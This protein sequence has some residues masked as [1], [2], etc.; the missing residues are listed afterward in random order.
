MSFLL[1][2]LLRTALTILLVWMLA[3]FL[4]SS[5]LVTGGWKAYAIIGIVLSVME[6]IVWPILL[7]ISFPLRLIGGLIVTILLN[8]LFLW[9]LL[10]IVAQVDPAVVGLRIAGGIVGWLLVIIALGIGNWV[11][12]HIVGMERAVA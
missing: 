1:R 6:T 5:F 10:K 12:R 8:A 4:P 2:F 3:D 9:L 7:L 11:I